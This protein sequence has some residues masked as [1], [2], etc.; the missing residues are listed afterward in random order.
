MKE[1]IKKLFAESIE[2]KEKTIATQLQNIEAGAQIMIDSLGKGNKILICGNGGSAADS[3]HFATELVSRFEKDR[4]ALPAIALT[5]DTSGLTATGN[6]FG[7][8]SVFS[9]QV[10]ALGNK[11]DI[12]IGFSTSGNSKNIIK[13][14]DVANKKEMK[15][16]TFLGRDGGKIKDMKTDCNII[17]P[18]NITARI[19]ECHET[20]YHILC[21]LIEDSLFD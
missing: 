3:Q 15:I 13:A 5:T 21:K 10:E 8:E 20:I 14:I 12:L 4:K 18:N 1:E 17:I 16:I 7:F 6:D 2:A 9:R 11:G 19:Q